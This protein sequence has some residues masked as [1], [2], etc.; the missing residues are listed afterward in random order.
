[1]FTLKNH[2]MLL[3]LLSVTNLSL[4]NIQD[5]IIADCFL[6][7]DPR[8]Q[9]LALSCL[10]DPLVHRANARTGLMHND[11]LITFVLGLK[12]REA[13]RAEEFSWQDA[14]DD[15][16]FYICWE[17]VAQEMCDAGLSNFMQ[18]SHLCDYLLFKNF[19]KQIMETEVENAIER[20]IRQW[21]EWTSLTPESLLREILSQKKEH[22]LEILF[23]G[24]RPIK[25][26]SHD[27]NNEWSRY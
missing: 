12:K 4:A 2:T 19:N 15:Q 3:S 1:M 16:R 11:D 6:D 22:I 24:K 10:R 14:P 21:V 25:E 7:E 20:Y 9:E 17:H 26:S 27:G 13:E 18:I 5:R 8:K 23:A